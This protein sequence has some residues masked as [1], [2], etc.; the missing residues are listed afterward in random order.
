MPPRIAVEQVDGFVLGRSRGRTGARTGGELDG[1]FVTDSLSRV[2]QC[3]RDVLWNQALFVLPPLD[4]TTRDESFISAYMQLERTLPW[5]LTAFGRY[6]GSA[7]MG[8]SKYVALFDDHDGDVDIAV[9]REALGL[10][11]DFHR[12]QALTVE[13]SHIDSLTQR[14]NELRLQWSGVLP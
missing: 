3:T 2:E 7:R 8:E 9:R 4:A 1:G 11:W 12:R 6:E 13:L 14:S 10:R 5:K